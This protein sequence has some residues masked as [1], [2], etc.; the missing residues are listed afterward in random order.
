M[1]THADWKWGTGKTYFTQMDYQKKII[2]TSDKKDIQIK[3]ITRVK[4]EHSIMIKQSIQEDITI[5]SSLPSLVTSDSLRIHELQHASLPCPTPAPRAH[6]NSWPLSRWC[7]PTIS[8]SVFHSPPALNLSQH[9]GL[10]QNSKLFASG[11][12]SIGVSVSTS[13][14]PMNIPDW[15]PL[16]RN[17]W[18]SL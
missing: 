13:V 14:L 1:G 15:S 3:T 10:F 6:P 11:G 5:I 18:I 17:G 8:F 7:H 2:L 12:Q 4:E 9:Q 16:G